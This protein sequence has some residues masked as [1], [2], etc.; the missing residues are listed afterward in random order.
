MTRSTMVHGPEIYSKYY[1]DERAEIRLKNRGPRTSVDREESIH[2][3]RDPLPPGLVSRFFPAIRLSADRGCCLGCSHFGKLG[4]SALV[5]GW[6]D[7]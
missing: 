2:R 7:H 1:G 6:A 3:D 5:C 4:T